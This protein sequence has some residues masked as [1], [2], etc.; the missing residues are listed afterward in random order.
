MKAIDKARCKFIQKDRVILNTPDFAVQVIETKEGIII[1]IF[2][3]HGDLIDTY[4]YW[5]DD[6]S[7]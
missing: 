3:R 5:R 1:D 4:N 2:H 7:D 6:L